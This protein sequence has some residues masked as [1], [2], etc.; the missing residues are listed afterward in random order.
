MPVF[1]AAASEPPDRPAQNATPHHAP[2]G[3]TYTGGVAAQRNV[4]YPAPAPAQQ[5]QGG[6]AAPWTPPV[7]RTAG[8]RFAE[9]PTEPL[10]D[11]ETR[12][13]ARTPEKRDRSAWVTIAVVVS[14]L[15]LAVAVGAGFL[16]WRAME[17]A[18]AAQAPVAPGRVTEPEEYPVSYA[19]EPLRVQVGCSAVLFLDLDEPRADAPEQTA[20]LRYD[21]RCGDQPP[22][23][24]LGA[25]AASGSQRTGADLD[26]AGC[27]RAIRTSPLGP[28]ADIEVRKGVAICVLTAAN[29]AELVLVEIIDVGGT[30]TAGLRATSWRV[31]R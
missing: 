22:R 20:D 25:G 3:G 9:G 2:V 1:R 16:S 17:M 15:A 8:P 7:Q 14:L 6:P 18:R 24:S 27:L 29:P 23:L 31:P 4:T 21:S 28:G 12:A 5:R 19:K 10:R 11:T 13:S 30:G 26:A